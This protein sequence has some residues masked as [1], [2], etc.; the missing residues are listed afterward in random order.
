V[1]RRT[2]DTVDNGQH[3]LMGCYYEFLR[4]LTRIGR[5][6][7]LWE[8]DLDVPLWDAERGLKRLRCPA[9]PSPFHFAAG[10]M[11]FGHLSLHERFSALRA[12]RTLV[13]R[14]GASAKDEA[15]TVAQALRAL[16]QGPQA[17][18]ALWD[19]LTWATLNADPREA[20]AR[21]LAAVVARAL[22]GPRSAS[23]FLLPALPL[24]ELYA[25]PARKF[26][27]ARGGS[28]HCRAPVDEVALEKGRL[29]G[30]RS[31]GE[32]LSASRVILAVPPSVVRR[33]APPGLCAVV[34]A[35]LERTTPIVSVTLWLDGPV[36]G[37]DFLGLLDG[38]TQWL[39]RTDRIHRQPRA[40]AAGRPEGARL[41][42]VR[43]G[44]SA[45]LELPTR[46]IASIAL[47]EAACA[48]PGAATVGLRHALVVKEVAA[49]L[50]P[51]P[52]LQRLRPGPEGPVAHLLL[53]GDWTDTGLPATLESAA[54]S[55]HRA[56]T[57]AFET[58]RAAA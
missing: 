39:F 23:R 13:A 55:G 1:E 50:A 10:V 58:E 44:A 5:R 15:P 52:E 9:L 54:L 48:L 7:E 11:R 37:P 18:R 28:V 14:F 56:A 6:S 17:R 53:A 40:S 49:T 51:A 2:G 41:A 3:A 31:G 29:L 43:S 4:L 34:P 36:A 45:W 16:R 30:V 38:E 46:E 19:P 27:E 21:L 26:I 57:L 33:I 32:L 42:C 20:S 47:R 25:E 22:L 8:S 24:S 12:G 35:A